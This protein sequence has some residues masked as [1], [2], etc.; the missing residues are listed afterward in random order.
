MYIVKKKIQLNTSSLEICRQ[1]VLP[2]NWKRSIFFIEIF[3]QTQVNVLTVSVNV[4]TA[5]YTDMSACS[6]RCFFFK[7]TKV[8]APAWL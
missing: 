5:S 1:T 3:T 6:S 8:I 2:S 4:L 7:N